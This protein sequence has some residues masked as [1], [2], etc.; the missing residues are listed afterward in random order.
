[1]TSITCARDRRL[2]P[3]LPPA[4]A[5]LP[6]TAALPCRHHVLQYHG[7]EPCAICGH[8]LEVAPVQAGAA[9]AAPPPKPPSAFPSEIV[10]GFLFL[11]SY[12]HASRHEI[13][14]T[15]GIGFI[16]NVSARRQL[17]LGMPGAVAWDLANGANHAPRRCGAS[18]AAVA[19]LRD[20]PCH[21]CRPR[22]A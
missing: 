15:L 19:T 12:D 14:K 17:L 11:G 1:M 8:R 20:C 16:L 13:L 4:L 10:P 6:P 2:Q 7:G 5:L 21:H 22:N 18:G 9:P 3:P